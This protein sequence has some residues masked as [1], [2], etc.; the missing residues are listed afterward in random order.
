MKQLWT[1]ISVLA[2]SNL[3]A[4]GGLVG[5]LYSS[6]RLNK[7]RVLRVRDVLAPT[8]ASEAAARAKE[9]AEKA[10][11][12]KAAQASER[13]ARP[14]IS[15]A[16]RLELS[17]QGDEVRRQQL[18]ALEKQIQ[19]LRESLVRDRLELQQGQEKL[20]ADQAA[21]EAMRKR[22]SEQDGTVQFRKTLSTLQELKPDQAKRALKEMLTLTPLS[23]G[24][25]AA[26]SSGRD[27]VVSYLNAM[28]G[29]SR[30]RIIDQFVQDDSRL[31]AELLE[32]LRTLGLAIPRPEKSTP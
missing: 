2:L 26:M 15:A 29:R 7:E 11:A 27:L 24:D 22:L 13:A 19:S 30:T 10:E 28:D 20:K 5:W 9:E 3:L 23:T 12:A 31:A 6:D 4:V 17:K 1:I 21:F 16:D 8:I 25:G 32:H 18:A 14:P